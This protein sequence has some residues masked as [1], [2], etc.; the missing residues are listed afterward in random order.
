MFEIFAQGARAAVQM[1]DDAE[2]HG[3]CPLLPAGWWPA[4]SPQ[5]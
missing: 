3:T 2:A 1:V 4:M 5:G